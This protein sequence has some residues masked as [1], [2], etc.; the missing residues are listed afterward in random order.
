MP[1][2]AARQG[3]LSLTISQSLLKRTSIESV[4]PSNHLI[5]CLLLLLLPSIFPSI[6]VF[7]NESAL[8]IRWPEYWS[9]SFSISPLPLISFRTDWFDL[10]AVPWTLKSLLLYRS[11]LEFPP[12]PA[13]RPS[14]RWDPRK[15]SDLCVLVIHNVKAGV[16]GRGGQ[17]NYFL[18][19]SLVPSRVRWV[20]CLEG[21][22]CHHPSPFLHLC[23]PVGVHPT[24]LSWVVKGMENWVF[25][26][27]V[28][29]S[30]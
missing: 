3:F 5:L 15:P 9:F 19:F 26:W 25:S 22:L 23:L 29:G 2:T 16:G 30:Y 17:V 27:R 18:P 24:R 13:C 1:W 8:S 4:M 14:W 7:S 21:L 10:L 11:S 6:R 20:L 12:A 28:L